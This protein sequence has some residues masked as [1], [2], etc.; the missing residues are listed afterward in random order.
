MSNVSIFKSGAVAVPDYLKTADADTKALAGKETTFRRVSIE[1]GVWRMVVGGKEVGKNTDRHLDVVIARAAPENSRTFYEGVYQKGVKAAPECFSHDGVR[2]DPKSTKP[3]AS[4]CSSCPQNIKG[5]GTNESRACRYSRR[6]AI[7]LANDIGGDIFSLSVPAASLFGSDTNKMS[8]Q[9]YARTLSAHNMGMNAVVTRL[10][11][12][13]DASTPKLIFEPLRPLTEAEYAT[14]QAKR[15]SDDAK[16]AVNT[17]V[18]VQ[19]ADQ[20]AAAPT[21][22]RIQGTID[23]PP[24]AQDAQAEPTVRGAGAKPETASTA[25]EALKKW[26]SDD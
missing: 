15:E 16:L 18:H 3:Q 17:P 1:G 20:P 21:T 25:E 4:H 2:P 7:L 22:S 26:A 23:T 10:H 5:S 19:D 24:P 14:V 11:F 8:L 9:Q 13:L 6:L 12:D